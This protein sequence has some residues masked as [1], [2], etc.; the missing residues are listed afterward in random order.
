MYKKTNK[1]IAGVMAF[2]MAAVP[3]LLAAMRRLHG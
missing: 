1:L 3:L 2:T